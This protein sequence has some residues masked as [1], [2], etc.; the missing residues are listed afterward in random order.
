[1]K[2]IIIYQFAYIIFVLSLTNIALAKSPE[3]IVSLA[4]STTEI[5]F[6]A[7]LGEK[8][9]GVTNFCDYPEEAKHKPKIGGMSNPSL[10]EVVSL[11][12]DIVVMTTDG[13]PR[14]FELK[15]HSLKIKTFVFESLTIAELPD[16]IRKMGAALDE[17]EK[18]NA[19]AA[20]IEQTMDKLKEHGTAYRKKVLFIVWP[21]PLIVAGQRT[22]A[23]DAIK[24]LGGVNIAEDAVG[25]Y[26]KYSIEEIF[27][28][29]PDI[30]FVGKGMSGKGAEDMRKLTSG[31]L[32]RLAALPAVK[33]NRVFFVSDSLFRLGPRIIDG[34]KE[35]SG[36][37]K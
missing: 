8:I 12:P 30:I 25:R 17:K 13:N 26:P 32:D 11:R 9:V 7:G 4:P 15:L 2:R 18:F 22:A 5:L 20:D 14:E 21:E 36:Y 31:L 28:Q 19:L 33:N 35:L 16:G 34:I 3:R 24:L 27:H 10:E 37:M 29:S 23:D 6:A 1:M